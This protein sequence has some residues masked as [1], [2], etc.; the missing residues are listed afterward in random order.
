[1]KISIPLVFF[2]LL[3]VPVQAETSYYSL[4]LGSFPSEK[5]ALQFYE[6]IKDYPQARI[7]QIG[8]YYTA[9]VGLWQN[10]EEATAF[11]DMI[12]EVAPNAQVRKAYYRQAR[13]IVPDALDVAPLAA[14]SKT[15]MPS[16]QETPTEHTQ[17]QAQ[18]QTQAPTQEQT[19]ASTPDDAD[20]QPTVGP[21][22]SS[23]QPLTQQSRP[24]HPDKEV[25]TEP[26]AAASASSDQDTFFSFQMGSFATQEEARQAYA[27][28]KDLP[29]A[30][31]ER[32]G[33]GYTARFGLWKD[34][35]GAAAFQAEAKKIVPD[36]YLRTARH[37]PARIVPMQ[38]DVEPAPSQADAT[39]TAA[40]P[41][42][43]SPPPPPQQDEHEEIEQIEQAKQVE[44]TDITPQAPLPRHIFYS[45]D[46]GSFS[47]QAEAAA[48]YEKIKLLPHARVEHDGQRYLPRFGLWKKEAPGKAYGPLVQEITSN[49]TLEQVSFPPASIV[50]PSFQSQSQSQAVEREET[51]EASEVPEVP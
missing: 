39:S 1:M 3:S 43:P 25:E 30:R 34:R 32:I 20:K 23:Q 19:I 2:L 37:D 13:L 27:Q 21:A 12:R 4:Q 33:N 50:L 41:E 26:S 8:Q 10:Q 15:K 42:P 11:L 29:D 47:N 28:I 24:P 16:V 7:E 51:G 36:A 17:A 18:E 49:A 38:E 14:G 45:Y 9:R 46:F 40:R 35:T 31:I 48:V 6:K 22:P 5:R 44:Q